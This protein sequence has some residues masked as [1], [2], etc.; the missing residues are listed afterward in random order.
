MEQLRQ[1]LTD[2]T[3]DMRLNLSNVLKGDGLDEKQRYTTALCCA[4]F[5]RCQPLA[6]AMIADGKD[7]LDTD[8]VE[9]AKAAAAIMSMV[10][11]VPW[12]DDRLF[13]HKS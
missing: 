9:D 11:L 5:L 1:R 6:E 4:Y 10:A 2:A 12:A 8:H 7:I 3:K 13:Y